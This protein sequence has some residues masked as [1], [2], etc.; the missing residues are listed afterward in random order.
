MSRIFEV[1][2][3]DGQDESADRVLL[4]EGKLR[5][6][7]NARLARD[8]R[9]EAR[10][11]YTALSMG[12]FG[13]GT[14]LASISRGTEMRYSPSALRAQTMRAPATSL[15]ASTSRKRS[16]RRPQQPTIARCDSTFAVM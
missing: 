15:R 2:L 14:L 3:N 11:A 4:P 10:P 13:G 1:Q 7:S 9:I 16:G 8:G 5:L 12:V 6:L